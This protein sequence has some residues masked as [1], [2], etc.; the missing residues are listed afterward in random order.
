MVNDINALKDQAVK[1]ERRAD[2]ERKKAEEALANLRL[3][4]LS[5]F[6]SFAG[7]G[8]NQIYTLDHLE[9]LEKM[10]VAVEIDV[11]GE[12][13]MQQLIEPI[14]EL[15]FFF[16]EGGRRPDL[17]RTAAGLLLQLEPAADLAPF[18]RQC[19]LEKWETRARFTPLLEKLPFFQKFQTRYYPEMVSVPL[20]ETGVFEM[21]SPDSAWGHESDERLHQVKLSPYQMAA[22]PVTFYQFALFCEAVDLGLVSRTPYWGRFGDHPVV[23]VS[24]YEAVEYANW[25]NAQQGRPPCYTIQKEKNADPDNLVQRGYLKWKVDWDTAAKGFR[26]PTE[27]EWELA[28]RGGVGAPRTLF[29]GSDTLDEIGWFWK[30]SGDSTGTTA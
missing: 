30:N 16:A 5:I 29:A 20:G 23:S 14:A 12:L 18:L 1:A 4:N 3:K 2:T 19:V 8:K 17:A 9:A 25:L 10:K 6:E 7:L 28:A 22:T 27:A 13:K 11:D 21:G 26:L 15:L 24:W